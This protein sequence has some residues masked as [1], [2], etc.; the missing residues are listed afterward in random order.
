VSPTARLRPA[1]ANLGRTVKKRAVTVAAD[2]S[3]CCDNGRR[4][5]L[6]DAKIC[7]RHRVRPRL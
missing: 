3:A 4:D 1:A 6:T 5:R 7:Q 2:T